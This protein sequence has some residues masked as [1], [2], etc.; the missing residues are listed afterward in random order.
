MYFHL[1]L[2]IILE[3]EAEVAMVLV[4]DPIIHHQAVAILHQ[5]MEEEAEVEVLQDKRKSPEGLF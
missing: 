3:A 2:N 4:T 5:T 1:S